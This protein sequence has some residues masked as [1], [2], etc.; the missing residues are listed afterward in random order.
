[1]ATDFSELDALAIDLTSAPA[2]IRPGLRSLFQDVSGDIRDEAR[3]AASRTGLEAY[4]AS[5]GYTTSEKASSI[6]SEVGPTPGRRQGSFGFVEDAG[7]GVKSAPQ[8]ALRD[9]LKHAEP[10]FFDRIEKLLGDGLDKAV[11]G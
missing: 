9:A 3:D 6:E 7:G 4:G 8:H 5:I 1:M 10:D 2:G 11:G